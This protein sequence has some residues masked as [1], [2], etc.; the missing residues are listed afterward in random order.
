MKETQSDWT[1]GAIIYEIKL[2]SCP[3]GKK[4]N[5]ITSKASQTFEYTD[6]DNGYDEFNFPASDV[7]SN[8]KLL[9]DTDGDDLDLSDIESTGHLHYLKFN[10]VGV[11][12]VN[13]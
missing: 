11:E 3:S 6:T 9:G 12:L 5:K 10:K 2:W 4:I 7:I 1:T 13:D 8:V